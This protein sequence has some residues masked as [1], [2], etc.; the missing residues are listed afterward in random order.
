MF[1]LFN[2][3]KI[4]RIVPAACIFINVNISRTEL[5]K[6]SL[7]KFLKY[8]P[9]LFGY[10]RGIFGMVY[11]EAYGKQGPDELAYT[12]AIELLKM[13]FPD[14]NKDG[15]DRLFNDDSTREVI[16]D[17][18]KDAITDYSR[19]HIGETRTSL[20]DYL[21]NDKSLTRKMNSFKKQEEME[22]IIKKVTKKK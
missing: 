1:G 9:Y 12:G 21:L 14:A 4:K 5:D 10:F 11:L 18:L 8:N 17:G 2:K 19:G 7:P 22:K 6:D 13:Y 15:V 3:G 16:S 20:A